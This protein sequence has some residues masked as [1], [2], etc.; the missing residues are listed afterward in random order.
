METGG[1]KKQK[2]KLEQTQTVLFGAASSRTQT[3]MAK[4]IQE[5][6]NCVILFAKHNNVVQT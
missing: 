3:N 4:I 5:Q 2:K 6:V 1:W